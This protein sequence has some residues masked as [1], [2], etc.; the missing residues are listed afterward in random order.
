[1]AGKKTPDKPADQAEINLLRGLE[2]AERNIV[3][4]R[5]DKAE[6]MDTHNDGIKEAQKSREAILKA[7]TDHRN[8]VQ[9]LPL[10]D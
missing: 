10:G 8:G 5:L 2:R 1:M 7:L 6:A 3:R 9:S 4:L